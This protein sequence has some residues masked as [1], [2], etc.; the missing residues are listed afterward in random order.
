MTCFR[1]PSYFSCLHSRSPEMHKIEPTT[2]TND[3]HDATE[4]IERE[5]WALG[6]SHLHLLARIQTPAAD[7]YDYAHSRRSLVSFFLH[8]FF[9]LNYSLVAFCSAP[10][11]LRGEFRFRLAALNSMHTRSV[12]HSHAVCKRF[13]LP[14]PTMP[15]EFHEKSWVH[16]PSIRADDQC[17]RMQVCSTEQWQNKLPWV[18]CVLLVFCSL[19]NPFET[20][21]VADNNA[22]TTTKTILVHKYLSGNSSG[23]PRNSFWRPLECVLYGKLFAKRAC[24][25]SSVWTTKDALRL[26]CSDHRR[27]MRN[28]YLVET[29]RNLS[30][31]SHVNNLRLCS[32]ATPMSLR[33]DPN[34]FQ[35]KKNHCFPS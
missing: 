22:T 13:A 16:S 10:L 30:H 21:T 33:T 9:F 28:Y 6:L 31:K 2:L 8:S 14:Q 12:C 4:H 20:A 24:D 27:I 17:S 15:I 34:S 29:L 32:G 11:C 1:L 3:M 18:L 25:S 23:L 19:F 5:H 7:D 35:V 26:R